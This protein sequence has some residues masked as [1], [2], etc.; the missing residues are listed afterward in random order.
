[1]CFYPK[2]RFSFLIN[3]RSFHLKIYSEKIIC[4]FPYHTNTK[5]YLQKMLYHISCQGLQKHFEYYSSIEK[6][7][8]NV[9]TVVLYSLFF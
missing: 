6:I 8:Q 4:V 1:M 3:L 9:E 5:P 2:M 7:F